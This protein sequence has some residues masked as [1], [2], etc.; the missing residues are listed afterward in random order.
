M[1]LKKNKN[2]KQNEREQQKF[3]WIQRAKAAKHKSVKRDRANRS[4]IDETYD[5]ANDNVNRLVAAAE[6]TPPLVKIMRK[7]KDTTALSL[8]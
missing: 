3:N 4:V 6:E 1:S 7:R 5:D 8:F 2:L